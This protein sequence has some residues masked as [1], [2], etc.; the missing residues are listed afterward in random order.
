LTGAPTHVSDQ[1]LEE[2]GLRVADP[3]KPASSQVSG[4]ETGDSTQQ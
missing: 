4:D 3:P 1:Q 2:V